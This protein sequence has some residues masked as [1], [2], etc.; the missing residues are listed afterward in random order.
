[1]RRGGPNNLIYPWGNTWNSDNAV[2]Y[3]NS[4]REPAQVGTKPAGISWVGAYD[5]SGNIWQW[6]QTAYA[7]YPY[8]T[9][10][11]TLAQATNRSVRGGSYA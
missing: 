6:L 3:S 8:D 5:M 2:W 1:M 4:G 11:D 10:N 7:D 9:R